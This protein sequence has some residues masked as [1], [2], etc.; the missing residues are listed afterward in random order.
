MHFI[1]TELFCHRICDL[2]PV[3]CQHNSTGNACF[4]EIL[5]RLLCMRLDPVRDQDMS[6]I[7]AIYRHMYDGS[8]LMAL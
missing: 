6:G 5:D 7:C 4:F 8:D 1:N 3:A 2:L